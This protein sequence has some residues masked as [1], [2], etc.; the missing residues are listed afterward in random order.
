MPAPHKPDPKQEHSL[1]PFELVHIGT[2]PAAGKAVTLDS[3]RAANCEG[4]RL[5]FT[6]RIRPAMPDTMGVAK[7]VPKFGLF[8]FM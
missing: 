3:M 5:L 6:A 8:S 2:V 7:L 4:V 1:A